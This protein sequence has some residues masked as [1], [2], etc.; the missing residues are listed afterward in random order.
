MDEKYIQDLYNQLGG[1]SKFGNFNDFKN[2]IKTD[3]QYQKDF[4]NS[5]GAKKLGEFNDFS[6]LVSASNQ[7]KKGSSQPTSQ[8]DQSV[9]SAQQKERLIS[10]V[11]GQQQNQQASA[12][13]DGEPK[14]GT[15]T[16]FTPE[17]QK[18]MKEK[19]APDY[20]VK[21][22]RE[23]EIEKQTEVSKGEL[24]IQS[25]PLGQ[26]TKSYYRVVADEKRD[27]EN[28]IRM[29]EDKYLKA[30]I[31]IEQIKT[32]GTYQDLQK[33]KAQLD[34][35]Y[36]PVENALREVKKET[37]TFTRPIERLVSS[38]TDGKYTLANTE[39]INLSK[40]VENKL[41]DSFDKLP[42]EQ[43]QK[44]AKGSLPTEAKEQLINSAKTDVLN[45]KYASLKAEVSD[46]IKNVKDNPNIPT[47]QKKLIQDQLKAKNDAF[48]AQL[49]VDF[50][51]NMLK[52]NFKSTKQSKDLDEGI[53]S[54]YEGF[55]PE[56]LDAV[57]TFIEGMGSVFTKGATGIP[58]L[59]LLGA[60][61]FN[62]IT[63]ASN[64]DDYTPIEATLD[65]IN[66]TTNYNFLPSS[67]TVEGNIVDEEGNLNLS[68]RSVTRSLANT[69][70][71]T[72]KIINDVKNG[73]LEGSP[74]SMISQ[75]LN[76]K[77]N[78][79]FR[80]ELIAAETAYKMTIGDNYKQ[81]KD[82]G[83][84]DANAFVYANVMSTAEGVSEKIMPDIKFFDSPVGSSIK[85]AFKGNL[86]KAATKEAAKT[87]TKD[88]FQNIAGEL[89]EEEFTLAVEDGL[90]YSLLLNHKNSEFFNLAKQKELA[91]STVIMSGALGGV[92]IPNKLK[93]SKKDIYRSVYN[94]IADIQD[95]F[96]AEIKSP[97][98]D[99]KTKETLYE[100]Y[101][102]ASDVANAVAKAPET[103]TA[104]QIDLLV[105]KNKLEEKKKNIDTAFHPDINKEIADID[106]KIA[107]ASKVKVEPVAEVKPTDTKQPVVTAETSSNFANMTQDGEGNFVFYHVSP[108]TLDVID[109]SKYGS[110]A[111]NVTSRDE[112]AAIGRV[113][114]VAM[115]YTDPTDSENMVNG[116]KHV[117]KVPES[118]V[119]DFNSDPENFIDE[120]KRQ[121]SEANPNMAF[122]PNDQFAWI[123]KVA[124]DNGY[125]MVVGEWGKGK[126]RAQTTQKL[127]PVDVMELNGNVVTKPF[128]KEYVG[129]REKGFKSVVPQSK[130]SKIKEAKAAIDSFRSRAGKY[131]ELYQAVSGSRP[132]M[133]DEEI[134]KLVD[135]S[136]IPQELKDQYNEAMAYE[137]GNRRTEAPAAA[138]E[139]TDD[140][141]LDNAPEGTFLNIGLNI[142]TTQDLMDK[143]D[144]ISMLPEGVEV[145]D[146]GVNEAISEIDG[147]ENKELTL[148]VKLSRPLTDV[149]MAK[150]LVDTKQKAIPQMSESKGAMH[151]TK[152][153]GDFN[154]EYFYMPDGSKLSDTASLT[155]NVDAELEALNKLFDELCYLIKF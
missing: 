2:L 133:T 52:N 87:V 111:G 10:A 72:L 67:K 44:W 30:G 136:D 45:E 109:P 40:D 118:E 84:T 120:A 51:G 81:A 65:L 37:T 24:L 104:D 17:Q 68:Y 60:E 75:L 28:Q 11:T 61:R 64:P 107:E 146:Q 116:N 122:S 71:F 55:L 144:V 147:K 90:K 79:Q 89:G 9:S 59:A 12:T 3:K 102:F 88:F 46:Y 25:P 35:E 73:R 148:S 125:K 66:D 140:V 21:K 62:Q 117:V 49:A 119:Y 129:N 34:E 31:D 69:L 43:K 18:S 112:K 29:F 41:I 132:N 36:R 96:A 115:F 78:K 38:F 14:I 141:S 23:K 121:F 149:E 56:T 6:G 27:V 77:N 94:N 33:K 130:Q 138:Y 74:Q 20:M 8:E 4:Y 99:K 19:P 50:S 154:P 70:P 126:T 106:A 137:P 63:G 123:T 86:K 82:L 48:N 57:S 113:G 42:Q 15:F 127:T 53:L 139:R 91:A 16:G 13:S 76:P 47:E 97:L 95:I 110:N 92:A 143:D 98:T 100:A 155:K 83:M 54:K 1:Q 134:K 114:G 128:E 101:K 150:F 105:Q 85:E 131:D 151:G 108:T 124:G 135:E 26:D 7:K 142:G 103:V 22:P 145:L 152:E 153:W 93:E 58:T 80:D 39:T 5:F 32:D